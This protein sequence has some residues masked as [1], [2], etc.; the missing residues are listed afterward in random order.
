MFTLTSLIDCRIDVNNNSPA[1]LE[2][3]KLMASVVQYLIKEG[4]I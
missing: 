1:G 4:K 2:H 3:C